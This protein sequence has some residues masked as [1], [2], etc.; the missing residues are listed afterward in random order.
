MFSKKFEYMVIFF[1]IHVL[2]FLNDNTHFTKLHKH[3]FTWFNMFK[4]ANTF[5]YTSH[6][7]SVE[8]MTHFCTTRKHFRYIV[9]TFFENATNTFSETREHSWNVTFF[10]MYET[11]FLN[12]TNIII[13]CI[14]IVW[15]GQYI[16]LEFVVFS[17]CHKLRKCLCIKKCSHFK[18]LFRFQKIFMFQ[19]VFAL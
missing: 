9:H 3:S 19:K 17:R 7:Y 8:V 2:H 4:F 5:F 15:I 16:F 12:H 6:V 13:H 14:N 11:F 10:R 1:E 18:I